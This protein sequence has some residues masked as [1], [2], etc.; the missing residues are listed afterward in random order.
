MK[1]LLIVTSI[2]SGALLTACS[3]GNS[4]GGS[5]NSDVVVS[6]MPYQ[7]LPESVVL[8]QQ[9][10][11]YEAYYKENFQ[12][13]EVLKVVAVNKNGNLLSNTWS[14][15]GDDG[16][17]QNSMIV[18]NILTNQASTP[19]IKGAWFYT[20]TGIETTEN[21][22]SLYLRSMSDDKIVVGSI[23]SIGLADGNY[24]AIGNSTTVTQLPPNTTYFSSESHDFSIENISGNSLYSVGYYGIYDNPDYHMAP[25]NYYAYMYNL[26]NNQYHFV[27]LSD[28]NLNDSIADSSLRQINNNGIAVGSLMFDNESEVGLYC[29]ISGNCNTVA[30]EFV[31]DGVID[32]NDSAF[33]LYAVNNQNVILGEDSAS[34]YDEELD[35]IVGIYEVRFLS[36][37]GD[38][39]RELSSAY[40]LAWETFTDDGVT[41]VSDV[42]K[43]TPYLYSYSSDSFIPFMPFIQTMLG[44]SSSEIFN[45][46]L[47]IEGMSQ[48][49]HYIYGSLNV[50]ANAEIVRVPF[51]IYFKDGLNN[52]LN[53]VYKPANNSNS[54]SSLVVNTQNIIA[55][56]INYLHKKLK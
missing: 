52:Y 40:R 10:V 39:L 6:I 7:N 36:S 11:I 41:L 32:Y 44:M 13:N 15:S 4:G 27:S 34:Y 2:L 49:G 51:T 54:A 21:P 45:N 16:C 30:S 22:R 50:S 1:R 47:L 12:W 23:Q 37:T 20:D 53:N 43:G 29:N 28:T 38:V 8:C 42:I 3:S 18:N 35:G 56:K 14:T 48:D 33:N 9:R 25:S 31:S 26:Q 19:A 55:N 46:A 5:G 24:A 17:Q